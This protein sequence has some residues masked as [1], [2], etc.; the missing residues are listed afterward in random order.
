[1]PV[2]APVGSGIPLYY[3]GPDFEYATEWPQPRL[4]AGA[5]LSCVERVFEDSTG[6]SGS[7][8]QDTMIVAELGRAECPCPCSLTIVLDFSC[9]PIADLHVI[10]KPH[11][12]T[13][14]YA[15]SALEQRIQRKMDRV[16]ALSCFPQ[17]VF[18]LFAAWCLNSTS[19]AG[20]VFARLEADGYV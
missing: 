4:G 1:M 20:L 15:K 19:S 9:R 2:G 17:S 5:F 16:Y 14:T 6:R 18:G 3:C 7:V 12:I 10:G 8:L 13:F 11:A